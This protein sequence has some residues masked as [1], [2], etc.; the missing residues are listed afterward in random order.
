M[1]YKPGGTNPWLTYNR[2][3]EAGELPQPPQDLN[4]QSK[5]NYPDWWPAMREFA[6]P[7]TEGQ[8][9]W[10]PRRIGRYYNALKSVPYAANVPTWIDVPKIET[11]YNML[12][13]TR[14]TD[15]QSWE[16]NLDADPAI[17]EYVRDW[18]PPPL[19]VIPKWEQDDF[20]AIE[21]A[22]KVTEGPVGEWTDYGID[23]DT[24]QKMP[25]EK[26][27]LNAVFR[28]QYG[29]MGQQAL[30]LAVVGS[31]FGPIGTVA[32]TVVGGVLGWK[33][34]E[35][36]DRMTRMGADYTPSL[37]WQI[38]EKLDWLYQGS[39]AVIGMAA[40]AASRA[41]L[42]GTYGTLEE[43]MQDPEA[44][45]AAGRGLYSALPATFAG[46]NLASMIA[47]ANPRKY[48]P[49]WLLSEYLKQKGVDEPGEF[50]VYDL[51]QV[52]NPVVQTP[53]GA[54]P[55]LYALKE[56]RDLL[57][58]GQLSP[59]QVSNWYAQKF[60]F[61]GEFT[62]LLGGYVL[63]PL[64]LLGPVTS[65]AI[66]KVGDV[67]GN[68]A[69]A[70][71]FGGEST[72]VLR[73]TRMYRNILQQM[74]TE[75]V[76]RLGGMTRWFAGLDKQGQSVEL[77]QKPAGPLGGAA[78]WFFGYTPQARAI[79]VVKNSLDGLSTMLDM[80]NGN[81]DGM[82]RLVN[83]FAGTPGRAVEAVEN[84][85]I[86]ISV[87]GKVTETD[88]P[89]WSRS[90]E[91]QVVPL[92]LKDQM[93]K[94]RDLY[95]SYNTAEPQR[96]LI[97]RFAAALGDDPIKL[98]ADL[99]NGK[100]D[101]DILIKRLNAMAGEGNKRAATFLENI[102]KLN[103]LNNTAL[104]KSADLFSGDG[105]VAFDGSKWAAQ[106]MILL[107]DGL[108]K[109]AVDWFKLKPDSVVVR[110]FALLKQGFTAALLGFNPN[111]AANNGA[112]NIVTM[113][114]DGLLGTMDKKSRAAYMRRFGNSITIRKGLG[115][116]EHGDIN[117]GAIPGTE[118]PGK[119]KKDF[120]IGQR[121][122]DAKRANDG[123]QKTSDLLHRGDKLMF[124]MTLS[125]H[126]ESWSSEIATVKGITEY[127]DIHHRAGDGFD[128]MGEGLRATLETLRPGLGDQV[129]KAIARGL[130][131]QEI[132][133]EIFTRLEIPALK[134]VLSPDEMHMMDSFPGL[135]DEIDK[136]IREAENPEETRAVFNGA[137]QKMQQKIDEDIHRKAM[138]IVYSYA[139]GVQAEGWTFAYDKLDTLVPERHEFWQ[140]HMQ[141]MDDVASQAE[142]LSGQERANLWR[143]ELQAA[144]DSWRTFQNAEGYK[145]LGIFEG[146]GA[147]RMGSEAAL[148]T[149]HLSDVH[150]VW[151]NFYNT[152]KT[153][154]DDYFGFVDGIDFTG[155]SKAEGQAL[156]SAKWS[157]I[158]ESLNAAYAES[159]L[160]EDAY[161]NELDAL[162]ALRVREQAG[163]VKA[164]EVAQWR[165]RQLRTRRTMVQ[166]MLIWRTG[167]IPEQV[168]KAW[169]T[170]LQKNT[171]EKIALLNSSEPIYR[172]SVGERD[173]ANKKFY[174]DIYRPL[175]GDL[176]KAEKPDIGGKVETVTGKEAAPTTGQREAPKER[177]QTAVPQKERITIEKMLAE[178]KPEFIQVDE[179]GRPD[180]NFR[181]NV[182]KWL[183]KWSPTAR[184]GNVKKWAEI[185]PAL[186]L[187]AWQHEQNAPKIE[188]VPVDETP[189]VAP[190]EEAA[191]PVEGEPV[192]ETS[193]E[194]IEAKPVEPEISPDD[195][196][197]T[198]ALASEAA[199]T[200][201]LSP[202]ARAQVETAQR[203]EAAKENVIAKARDM[204]ENV[205]EILMLTPPKEVNAEI[206]REYL[207][208][209]F[210]GRYPDKLDHAA[211][212]ADAVWAVIDRI[213]TTLAKDAGMTKDEWYAQF[214]LQRGGT[215]LGGNALMRFAPV[216][217]VAHPWA[218]IAKKHFG[219]T[220]NI[221][222]AGYILPD[223]TM[224]DLTGRHYAT[225][226][227]RTGDKFIPEAGQPDY[228]RQTRSVDHRELPDVIYNEANVSGDNTNNLT[229]LRF[230]KETGAVR[231]SY[232]AGLISLVSPITSEQAAILRDYYADWS[233]WIEVDDPN[234]GR[235]ILN[236]EFDG[237]GKA[238]MRALLSEAN[239]KAGGTQPLFRLTDE[240][241]VSRID[242]IDYERGEDY[243]AYSIQYKNGRTESDTLSVE[244]AGE[245][246]GETVLGRMEGRV[247]S[248]AGADLQGLNRGGGFIRRA[249][250]ATWWLDNGKAVIHAFQRADVA[251]VL[252]EYVHAVTPL[253]P[254][255][256]KRIIERWYAKE[257]GRELA[258]DWFD[259][260]A[261]DVDAFEKLARGF[262]R[263]MA[264][265]PTGFV[266][267]IVK[268]F[269]N[270][271]SWMLDIYKSL[272]HDDINI[273]M[274][275]DIRG[276]F[277]RW[278]G[279]EPKKAVEPEPPSP[280]P[281]VWQKRTAPATDTPE[282]R[283][284]FGDSKVVDANGKPV[285]A[286]HG[287]DQDF[288]IFDPELAGK[289]F[290]EAGDKGTSAIFFTSDPVEASEAPDTYNRLVTKGQNV[291]KAYL[292]I[293]K[294][295]RYEMN[296][297]D[298]QRYNG[299]PTV[300]F[301]QN[302]EKIWPLVVD[303]KNDG[304]II[305]NPDTKKALYVVF[306]SEQAKSVF[307]RG[308]YSGSNILYRTPADGE[309][310]PFNE[311]PA[312]GA[313]LGT[314]DELNGLPVEEITLEGWNTHLR[315]LLERAQRDIIAQ[316]RNK[317]DL[318]ADLS[319]EGKVA[320]RSYLGRVYTQLAD[321]KMAAI[322]HGESRRNAALLDYTK[323]TGFDQLA[324]M[325]FP[326]QFWYTRTAIN[327][328]LRVLNKPSI[329]ANY[330]RLMRMSQ[331]KESDDGYPRRLK[332]KMAIPMPW[333]PDW[334][335]DTAYIDPW[336][337]AFPVLQLIRP[338][339]KYGE[340]KNQIA[341][342]TDQI[343]YDML[344]GGEITDEQAQ[345]AIDTRTGDI[346][347]KAKAQAETETERDFENPLDFA[348]ALSS[349]LLPLSWTYDFLM[350]RQDRIGQLPFTRLVQNLTA[351]VGIGGPR[352]VNLEGP[353]RKGLGLPEIDRFEDYRV[354]RDLAS[355]VAEGLIDTN[356][357]QAAMIDRQ[358][359]AFEDA[360][361]RVSQQGIVK[362]AGGALALDLFPEGEAIQRGL[363]DEFS[364]AYD[365]KAAGDKDAVNK[366][367]D[368]YPEY[369]A[370]LLTFKEPEEQMRSFL[371]SIVWEKY[372][373]LPSAQRKEFREAAGDVFGDAF[374][375]TETRS[376]DSIST[377][378]FAMWANA[379][380]DTPEKAGTQELPV[381]WLE[382]D[383]AKAIDAYY[384]E[385]TRLF[386]EYDPN[387][388]PDPNYSLWQ[389]QYLAQHPAII[390]YV[391]GESNKLYGL[392][393]DIQRYVYN[394]RATRDAKY[395][396][397]F[398]IQET[399]FT[400]NKTQRKAFL[401]AHPALPDYWDWRKQMAANFP[402]AAA[403]IMSE[404]SLSAE[405]LDED[406]VS[407][408]GG[409]ST[410]GYTS[411]F[412]NA[413]Y[414]DGRPATSYHPPYLT[415]SELKMI[416][417]PLMLQLFAKFYRNEKLM[418]GAYSE[419][420]DIWERLGKPFGSI[421]DFIEFAVRPTITQ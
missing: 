281:D 8:P 394:Y 364:A 106:L 87:A 135:V 83:S 402:K 64:D 334:M 127:M 194:T 217:D 47:N 114:W 171:L 268:V 273:R 320:L 102:S 284:W 401:K 1:A 60:G 182:I 289:N 405:I 314:A 27:L 80:E 258:P 379:L 125:Q 232:D 175:I 264:E 81:V 97:N 132:E 21:N 272:K 399:Y 68:V 326:Y 228:L 295:Y 63:D 208:E 180:P 363:Q 196:E 220:N 406:Y 319:Q 56:A 299:E 376:Y 188:A 129:E 148:V 103:D 244:Q 38:M 177:Q 337:Q 204:S 210:A 391:V 418:P 128:H 202:E 142:Q 45:W 167:K 276:L 72:D 79:N 109:W 51:T 3:A 338:F 75:E 411:G 250:G 134:D 185:T 207:H 154:M 249:G 86:K 28:S 298:I 248:L 12:R 238:K 261:V 89:R 52:E 397:I 304:V 327:W 234:T 275:D 140:Q 359:Q 346:Y 30:N 156:R 192:Q 287:T 227:K 387:K 354:N 184:E 34:S 91:A 371:R 221:H 131:K 111:Y 41:V 407:T 82:Y 88:M 265:G 11:A 277:D 357:A 351:M 270:I 380:G 157:E 241:F 362:F 385:S 335:G 269:E 412:S 225:G 205:N 169:G 404:E 84:G 24:W 73:N 14:F 374:L 369:S 4:P 181:L 388:E 216:P 243:V 66:S 78:D 378:T 413:T 301:D 95:D 325:I 296:A 99:H 191:T 92:A 153:L 279:A 105:A 343:V 348:K 240:Q 98:L 377:D 25:W 400:L 294:P 347:I 224:L 164:N 353:L 159:V 274:N 384:A 383:T 16:D 76:M 201:G 172:M 116:A 147:E 100:T 361:R 350:G 26:K 18:A 163:T 312:V 260:D 23:Y 199:V 117:A 138:A 286:Y 303:G 2:A 187:E 291:I 408:S 104:K 256:D 293:E 316:P 262:E 37:T 70:K 197:I 239:D 290:P 257:Y 358:G 212:R 77:R 247:G 90:A 141:H 65:G 305:I 367:F 419:I 101:Y 310:N 143:T 166:A 375:N 61:A 300:Y 215:E 62:E 245:V 288:Q 119:G 94:V 57:A 17:K 33:A 206:F 349:P 198:S 420:T 307:N 59:N 69:L 173:Q 203:A 137:I 195:A 345:E 35:E 309:G 331:R 5:L 324:G 416:S 306:S 336:R 339:E 112:N 150:D 67:T 252:H 246:L 50:S 242:R 19:A 213:T 122:R 263:Y 368:K 313:P 7:Q 382:D 152:R 162:L 193:T 285:A 267:E 214:V 398:D 39:Q 123:V 280:Q 200:E 366:F 266:G 386:G 10:T 15:W 121:I 360:Q 332:G 136:G 176:M 124:A 328:A 113:A 236:Q 219:V 22:A 44:A 13:S 390:K 178:K 190:V 85:K 292:R 235:S 211:V 230:M 144:D 352:G 43:M 55:M 322:R 373:A 342:R 409:S 108:E 139:S 160:V 6:A 54:N 329:L 183:R 158:N 189:N 415:S 308:T 344:E 333:L 126:M 20:A 414:S 71:A 209:V 254:D 311:P 315:P 110:F 410:G 161:Q 302:K 297:V 118:T 218:D 321:T 151:G 222:E 340:E 259:T 271:K 223:G 370:R 381:D 389:N 186:I 115:A 355:M 356:T 155:M 42:P 233:G 58:S 393:E 255:G 120:Q 278:L 392:P 74:P 330:Y 168:T 32:G 93:P 46:S 417:Q 226:Y 421:E 317:I 149:R 165:D 174:R 229:M 107:D 395:P 49:L 403:Y 323:R 29:Q 53:G 396:G 170:L 365:A 251:D 145:W 36:Q 130:N 318:D 96:Q 253:L 283:A 179:I 40:Q 31:G 146:F 237:I 341:R 9:Y 372:L 231:I 48:T 282:F 133:A